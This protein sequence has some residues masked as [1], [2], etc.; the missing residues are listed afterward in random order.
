M[1]TPSNNSQMHN[2][3]MAAGS[4]ELPLMLAPGHYAQ[5]SSRFMRYV[6]TKTNKDQIRHFIKQGPYKLIELVTKVVPPDGD[7]PGHPCRVEQETYANTTSENRKL[8]DSEAEAILMILN[9]IGDDIYSIVDACSTARE[10]W[11]VIERLQQG[12]SINKKDVKTK[13]F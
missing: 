12:E 11:L 9:E 3:I 10:L 4:K 13:L 8:S 5:W 1:T 2:D 6:D 7:Q